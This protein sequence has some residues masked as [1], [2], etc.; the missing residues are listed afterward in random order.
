MTNAYRY[1]ESGL[2]NVFIEGV[3]FAMDDAG[4]QVICIPNVNG[5]H[6]AIA[7]A[8]VAREGSISGKEL[9]FLRTEA[10][11]TQAGLAKF[12]HRE[13]LAISRWERGERPIDSNA[14]ALIRLYMIEKLDLSQ[15]MS[16]QSMSAW[17]VTS[18]EEKPISIDGSD[19]DNY[20]LI[21]A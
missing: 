9:K 3:Q 20:H 15:K 4:E 13:P 2:D 14:E 6:R 17:C 7:S 10:G 5:L 19:P 21:A 16:V 1:T 11:L 8:V 18:A 12:V